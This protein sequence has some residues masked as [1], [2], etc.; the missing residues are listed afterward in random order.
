MGKEGI[1]MSGR[2]QCEGGRG[3][4]KVKEVRKKLKG[5]GGTG[6]SGYEPLS[7]LMR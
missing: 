5:E 4:G 2:Q 7:Y 1:K 3:E 6:I